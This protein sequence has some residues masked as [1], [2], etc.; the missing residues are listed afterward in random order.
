[1]IKTWEMNVMLYGFLVCFPIHETIG[2]EK[3]YQ[4]TMI[5]NL[6]KL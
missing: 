6:C 3:I 1:M 4:R 5:L 2:Q